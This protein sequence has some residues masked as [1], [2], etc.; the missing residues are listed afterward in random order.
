M[1]PTVLMQRHGP[2]RAT[3]RASFVVPLHSISC[4]PDPA[5]CP[6]PRRQGRTG[7]LST[8]RAHH[9]RQS[10]RYRLTQ[11]RQPAVGEP[12]PIACTPE[13]RTSSVFRVPPAP[14]G[15]ADTSCT[16]SSASSRHRP[17]PTFETLSP[18]QPHSQTII[19]HDEMSRYIRSIGTR[20]SRIE[21][22]TKDFAKLAPVN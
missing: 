3:S 21:C 22:R 2:H 4:E 6:Q 11:V 19:R 13:S 12:N 7:G 14:A 8:Y 1:A 9:G 16:G 15:L 18:P 5:R 20:N 17:T 10:T